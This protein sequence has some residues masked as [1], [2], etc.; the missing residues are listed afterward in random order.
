VARLLPI[1][2]NSMAQVRGRLNG[3]TL[4]TNHKIAQKGIDMK[5]NKIFFL[6]GLCALVSA[7][8]VFSAN[9]LASEVSITETA[10]SYYERGADG[11]YGD[12]GGWI[13]KE[14]DM[15]NEYEEEYKEEPE[16]RDEEYENTPPDPEDEPSTEEPS[17]GNGD[18]YKDEYQ[19]ESEKRDEQYEN[20]PPDPEDEPSTE[21]P[22]KEDELGTADQG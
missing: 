3:K 9:V 14:G 21:E 8:F 5:K 12:S 13:D 6:P 2:E 10:D 18:Y 19:D 15:K 20:A 17:G 22:S 16:E 4:D 11:D 7:L 1:N